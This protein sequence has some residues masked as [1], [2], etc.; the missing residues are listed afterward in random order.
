MLQKNKTKA[1]TQKLGL[2]SPPE[3]DKDGKRCRRAACT[4]LLRQEGDDLRTDGVQPF[5][6]LGL[7]GGENKDKEA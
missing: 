4:D 5:G 3:G 6:D 7:T 1:Q 2:Q